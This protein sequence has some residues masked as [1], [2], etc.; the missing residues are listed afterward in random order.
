MRIMLAVLLTI[1][2][3]IAGPAWSLDKLPG[4]IVSAQ[5]L[6]SH[7]ADVIV[8]DVRDDMASFSRAPEYEDDPK[9][10]TKRLVAG[11][12]R[13]PGSLPVDFG[14]VRV[15]REIDG[16]RLTKLLPDAAHFQQ[17][18]RRVGL[19]AGKPVV[20]SSA[21]ESAD[22]IEQATRLYWTLRLYGA[23]ELAV[24]DGGIAAWLEAG[25]PVTTEAATGVDEGDWTAAPAKPGLLAST[26]EVEAAI[27][28]RQLI[29]AR[30][31]P[32]YFGLTFRKPT[33]LAGGH[34][35]GARNY[36]TDLRFRTLGIAQVFLSPSEY[37]AAM[38]AQLIDTRAS[39]IT[40]CNT[41]HMAAGLWFI[42]SEVLGNPNVGLYDGSMHEW[43]TLGKPVVGLRDS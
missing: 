3:T 36:P 43:T 14:E 37:R 4:P 11:G 26:G 1:L 2:L 17:T 33:V 40:Y 12:G 30:P 25:Y 41:G 27:G 24:L 20:I 6:Q 21:G 39:T 31:L 10:R 5:W 15:D 23:G 7:L 28:K 22:Q 38:A 8:L 35:E 34:I 9:T 18:M 42:M 32:Q 19:R 16:R 29:D 13:I